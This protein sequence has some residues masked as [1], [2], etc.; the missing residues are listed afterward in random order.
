[1]SN[2]HYGGVIWTNHALERLKRRGLSQDMAIQTFKHPDQSFSGNQSDSFVYE[3]KFDEKRVSVIAKQ[4]EK[5]E[6]VIISCWMDPPM[7]GSPD[8]KEK[9]EYRQY[10]KASGWEKILLTIKKQLGF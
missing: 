9:K 7:P 6:W 3:K 2:S 4:N 1:M 8:A 5:N 10:Q